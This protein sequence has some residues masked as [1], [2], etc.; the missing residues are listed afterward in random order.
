[1]VRQVLDGVRVTTGSER[2]SVALSAVAEYVPDELVRDTLDAVSR[3][4][5]GGWRARALVA[6]APRLREADLADALS[7]ARSIAAPGWRVRALVAIAAR[8]EPNCRANVLDEVQDLVDSNRNVE[9]RV[10]GLIDLVDHVDDERRSEFAQ[11][12]LRLVPTIRNRSTRLRTI[13]QLAPHLEQ[14]SRQATIDTAVQL[15]LA[16]EGLLASDYAALLPLAGQYDRLTLAGRVLAAAS[17][18]GRD[19]I[20]RARLISAVAN[21]IVVLP[22]DDGYLVWSTALHL[23]SART[24]RDV[25]WELAS[26]APLALRLGGERVIGDAAR[27]VIHIAERWP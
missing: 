16:D 23:S 2:E 1:L 10:R 19:E 11:E 3:I 18:G 7:M 24:R 8:L 25:L 12:A 9:W 15:A 14:A 20:E 21:A 27:A 13:A 6:L 5:N 4:R 17:A 26:L 22:V